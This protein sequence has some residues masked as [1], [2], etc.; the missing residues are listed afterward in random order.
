[1]SFHAL[2]VDCDRSECVTS[3]TDSTIVDPPVFTQGDILT[4]RIT[5]LTGFT[6]LTPY[7]PTPVA[8]LTLE[9]AIGVKVGNATLYYASQF[10]W[11]PSGDLAQPYF[12]GD[13]SLATTE[14]TT[15]LGGNPTAKA[16]FEVKVIE[17]GEPWTVLQ[18]QIDVNAAVIKDGGMSPTVSPTP[19]SAET[20]NALYLQRTIPC[21][22][23][24]PIILQ[25]GSVTMALYLDTDGSFQTV[26][27]T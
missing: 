20:A 1:M 21:S 9:V 7:T 19:L 2:F 24:N 3:A 10:T 8:G 22:A 15:L 4:L 6:R 23:S 13:L 16:F 11:T 18:K 27:L 25:N 14:I 17:G 12:E 26:R 5:L